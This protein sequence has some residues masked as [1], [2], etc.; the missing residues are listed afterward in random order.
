MGSVPLENIANIYNFLIEEYYDIEYDQHKNLRGFPII[1][2][3]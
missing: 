3:F 2:K 1:N